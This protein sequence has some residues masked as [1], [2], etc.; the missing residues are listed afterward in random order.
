MFRRG[1]Q[2]LAKRGWGSALV[3]FGSL[4][5]LAGGGYWLRTV[6]LPRA[7]AQQPAAQPAPASQPAPPAASSDYP[8]RVVAYLYGSEVVTREE[9]GEYLIE[10]YGVEKLDTLVN[11]RIIEHVCREQGIDVAGSEVEA[12]LA[13]SMQGVPVDRA[14]FINTVLAKYRVTL[15]EWKEDIIRPKLMLNKVFRNKAQATEQEIQ[16]LYIS[17]YGEKVECQLILWPN[18]EAG[19][20]QAIEAY[21]KIRG[22]AE[23]FEKAAKN[24]SNGNLAA[25]GGHVQP[26]GRHSMDDENLERVAFRLQ[27]G[28]LSEVL[29]TA[30]GPLV[31]KCIRHIPGDSSVTI[32]KVR[33]EL[34]KEILDR[35][36]QTSVAL[37]FR[38]V[39]SHATPELFNKERVKPGYVPRTPPGVLHCSEPLAVFNGNIAITREDLG[40]F[41]I[42]RF[43]AEKLEFLINKRI[44]DKECQK[45][46]IAVTA[47]EVEASLRDDLRRL[48][49]DLK[50][51]EKDYL[52]PYKKNLYEW[53][54]DVIRPRLLMTKVCRDRVRVTDQDLLKA[55]EKEYGEQ[56][57]C[58]MILWPPDQT[59]FAMT[60]Y[61]QIRDNPDLFDEKAKRQTST[62]LAATGG[63]MPRFGR[64]GFGNDDVES[65]VFH[66]QPGDVSTLV[67]T[68][69][70][71]VVVKLVQKFPAKTSVTL[72]SVREKLFKEVYENKIQ[73]DMQTAFADLRKAAQPNQL[74]RDPNKPVDVAGDTQEVMS[75]ARKALEGDRH[76][77]LSAQNNPKP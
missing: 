58:K 69:Q 65:Q 26:F 35:K 60:E 74:L 43:G 59:K 6:M 37:G 38:E 14:T 42:E 46:G 3:M 56:A 61:T 10:R 31:L 49:V 28:E 5:L 70:G 62:T 20:K 7:H 77:G 73:I 63:K 71:Y 19:K 48:N 9:L 50:T 55:Y 45:R 40:E 16:N 51:F 52:A 17:K 57:E 13:E 24:Q 68:P 67:G 1:K 53:K 21:G 11:K 23:E 64:G 33:D 2:W 4:A 22:S 18:N 27:P 66:M 72:E 32:D 76:P 29:S 36:M 39:R 54:E 15:V 44:I 47:E 8:R 41:L 30:Q 75:Q 25:T 12:S 34:V